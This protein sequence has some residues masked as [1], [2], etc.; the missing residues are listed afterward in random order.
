VVRTASR[1]T[2]LYPS[3]PIGTSVVKVAAALRSFRPDVVHLASPAVLGATGALAARRL[4]IPAVAVYQTDLAGFAAHYR[5]GFLRTP[6]WAWLRWIH[7]QTALT[8]APSSNAKWDLMQRGIAPVEVWGRGVDLDLFHPR[9]RTA[10]LR[11][12]WAPDG[13]LIVGYVGRLGAEK[14]PELLRHAL[15]LPGVRVVVVGDGPIRSQLERRLP[16]AVFTGFLGGEELA[17][18]HASFDVF[19]HTGIAETFCQAVQEAL[20][21]GVPVIAPASGGP[22]DLVRHGVDG[23]L[24]QP[25]RPAALSSIVRSAAEERPALAAMGAA[26]RRSV[27]GRSW[28]ALV[29]RLAG[30][31]RRVAGIPDWA[32]Q[33]TA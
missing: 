10:R 22:M 27:E 32:A 9:R 26:A 16:G 30:H 11:R 7:N 28:S 8:L 6:I 3:L 31:Y 17:R 33:E 4:G 13:Q 14:Q 5:V 21:S 20:A 15:R 12:R 25:G 2:S 23:W 19:L 24:W 1:R 18:A 29:D